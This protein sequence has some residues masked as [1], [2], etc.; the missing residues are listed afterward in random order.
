MEIAAENGIKLG[1]DQTS[2]SCFENVNRGAEIFIGGVAPV[3]EHLY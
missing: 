2:V 1:S 3:G